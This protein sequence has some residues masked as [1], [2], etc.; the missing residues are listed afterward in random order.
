MT[1][2]S[3]QASVSLIGFAADESGALV[4]LSVVGHKVLIASV[5]ATLATGKIMTASSRSRTYYLRG[6]DRYEV[7]TLPMAEYGETHAVMVNRRALAGRWEPGDVSA[8]LLIFATA[9]NAAAEARRLLVERLNEALPIPV[10]EAWAE[11]IWE[12]AEHAG[13]LKSLTVNGDVARGY[14]ILLHRDWVTLVHDLIVSEQIL[15][16]EGG[17]VCVQPQ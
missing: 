13:F 15:I 6:A 4:Y 9:Q 17:E 5:K 1:L 10:L 2:S 8:Y 14:E 16:A 3:A 12:A 11:V 7:V